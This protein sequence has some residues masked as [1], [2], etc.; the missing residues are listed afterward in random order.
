MNDRDNSR[1]EILRRLAIA[2]SDRKG[3]VPAAETALRQA[4]DLVGLQAS[5][6]YLWDE[7][8]KV[9]LT[10][11][12]AL[13]DESRRRLASLEEDLF[14]SLRKDRHVI[15]AYITLGGVTPLHSFTQPL[16]HGDRVFGAVIWI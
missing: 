12:H 13:T 10:A 7:N 11:S 4:T 14:R 6:M 9:N 2:G 3:L 16:R 5:A 8:M 1:F 15:S